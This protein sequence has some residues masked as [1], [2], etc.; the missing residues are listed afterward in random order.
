MHFI[1]TRSTETITYRPTMYIIFMGHIILSPVPASSKAALVGRYIGL[2]PVE[3]RDSNSQ[4]PTSES[5]VRARTTAPP[6][7]SSQQDIF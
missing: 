4:P 7:P 5:E 2:C 1:R 3:R 6:R